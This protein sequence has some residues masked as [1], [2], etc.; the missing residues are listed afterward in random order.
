MDPID[1]ECKDCGRDTLDMPKGMA[2][3]GSPCGYCGSKNTRAIR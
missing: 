1:I 2:K 3:D